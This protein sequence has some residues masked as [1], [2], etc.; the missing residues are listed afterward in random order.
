MYVSIVAGIY[1]LRTG[2]HTASLRIS[3]ATMLGSVLTEV[4]P[5]NV[6]RIPRELRDLPQWVVYR[7]ET[8]E[9]KQA[10]VPYRADGHGKA[11]S[12]SPASWCSFAGA[13]EACN[14][15]ASLAGV[16]FVFAAEDPY[17]GIDLDHCIENGEIAPWALEIVRDLWSY[18][19]WSRSGDGLHI[20]VRAKLTAPGNKR[21]VRGAGRPDA[22]IEM[23]DSGRYFVMTGNRLADGFID[24]ESRQ[25]R[26][27][28][29][30]AKYLARPV[31]AVAPL[32]APVRVIASDCNLLEQA[33]SARN[34]SAFAALFERGDMSAYSGDHSSADAALCAMLAFWTGRDAG[35]ID[36]LFRC[37]KLMRE[38]W[39][40]R[41]SSDGRTYGQMTVDFATA[42][43][44]DIYEPVEARP[45][46]MH[47]RAAS[48]PDAIRAALVAEAENYRR[49]FRMSVDVPLSVGQMNGVRARVARRLGIAL[50]PIAVSA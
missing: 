13:N 8:R 37:S 11:S 7:I 21:P 23:Y 17:V 42:N 24:I 40:A 12:T 27:D 22:A 14:T 28:A 36:R 32:I 46:L 47:L 9:G 33:R 15:D 5:F 30:H 2:D 50:A 16:G 6:L 10:K 18:T 44:H 3:R 20:I 1:S 43:C 25:S 41:H 38:K 45:A 34:G 31:P 4:P 29:L 39:N 26:V 48:M 49:N 35:R 19:E